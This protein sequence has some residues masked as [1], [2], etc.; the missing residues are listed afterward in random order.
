M[1]ESFPA[2]S[3]ATSARR[4]WLLS[5]DFRRRV[6]VTLMAL[7]VYRIAS[8][9]ALPGLGSKVYPVIA[10][11]TGDFGGLTRFSIMALGIIPLL[12]AVILLEVLRVFVEPF[13]QWQDRSRRNN[14]LTMQ[15]TFALAL[16]MA[17]T[18]AI[19]VSRALG[20]MPEVMG[21]TGMEFQIGVVASLF[22][23]TALC[24]MLAQVITTR[25][26]GAGLWVIVAAN[27][28]LE[29]PGFLRSLAEMVRSGQINANTVLLVA[30]VYAAAIMALVMLALAYRN[31]SAAR[32]PINPGSL[33]PPILAGFIVSWIVGAVLIFFG[34]DAYDWYGTVQ[35]LAIAAQVPVIIAIGWLYARQIRERDGAINTFAVLV[36]GIILSLVTLLTPLLTQKLGLPGVI[37]GAQLVIVVLSCVAIIASG[38]QSAPENPTL[39]P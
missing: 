18:Q 36:S 39:Q 35:S 8:F 25:G 5:A 31:N 15:W 6:L 23:G 12:S 11:S 20:H 1:I 27:S 32:V 16:A 14:S 7:G 19:G 26:V 29:I 34:P 2:L 33:W 13:R 3:P 10:S 37:S 21:N 22:G 17:V 28:I 38:P 9:I 4:D 30:L 24:I